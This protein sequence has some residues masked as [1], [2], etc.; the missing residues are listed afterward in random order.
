MYKQFFKLTY[1]LGFIFRLGQVKFLQGEVLSTN[2]NKKVSTCFSTL[3]FCLMFES[4][5]VCFHPHFFI[6]L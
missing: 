6:S 2:L 1:F 5:L 3:V 4:D